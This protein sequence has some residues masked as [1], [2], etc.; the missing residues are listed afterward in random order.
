NYNKTNR[1]QVRTTRMSILSG[2]GSFF[3]LDIGTSCIRLVE[4]RGSGP[5]KALVRYGSI[6]VDS[7]I[8]LSEAEA[9]QRK[10]QKAIEELIGSCG[11]TTNNVAVGIPSQR[12]FT[13]IADLDRVS[14]AEL[15]KTM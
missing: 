3:G 5:I 2:V 11:V 15:A 14:D 7:N 12:V 6:D 10:I 4:L 9:D 8:A 1:K 13:T